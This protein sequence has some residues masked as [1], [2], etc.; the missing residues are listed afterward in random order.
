VV[1]ISFGRD[2]RSNFPETF[3]LDYDRLRTLKAEID[4]LVMFDVCMDMFIMLTRQ[5][6]YEGPVPLATGQ[7][8]RASLT[9]I[10]GDAIGHGPR[11]WSMNSDALSL[12]ILRQ[13]SHLAGQAPT[14][15][16]DRLAD[17]N[18][19]LRHLFRE[20][21]AGHAARLED[22]LLPQILA[23]VGRHSTSSSVDIFNSLISLSPSTSSLPT[24]PSQPHTPDTFIFDHLNPETAKLA[25]IANRISHIILLHWRV[26]GPI[27]Y[28]RDHES[29]YSPATLLSTDASPSP[30][31]MSQT[32]APQPP[33]SVDQE[34]SVPT[35]MRIG[36]TLE[37]G[38]EAHIAHQSLPQ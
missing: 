16:F 33:P 5:L 29:K 26:W 35:S 1:A 17:A 38:Q 10:M 13:A 20:A 25:D 6:G 27:A 37:P 3:F 12:E 15:H 32:Q 30:S 14:Y 9:A 28:V 19:C 34:A 31:P 36:E 22:Y 8:L 21:P 23:S 7:Q 18:Q 11:Y 24:F 2:G 4:D